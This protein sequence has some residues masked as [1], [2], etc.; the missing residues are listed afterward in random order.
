MIFLHFGCLKVHKAIFSAETDLIAAKELKIRKEILFFS[1]FLCSLAANYFAMRHAS[2]YSPRVQLQREECS[3]RAD[4]NFS[5][6]FVPSVAGRNN[7]RRARGQRRF[8]VLRR[9]AANRFAFN[10][11]QLVRPGLTVVVSPSSR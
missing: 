1:A 8:R 10:C 6:S 7:P 5:A 3:R 9:V 4:N 11:P 2:I